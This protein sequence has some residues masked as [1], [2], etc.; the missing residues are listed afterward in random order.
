[1]GVDIIFVFKMSWK[2]NTN[3]L[4]GVSIK[5]SDMNYDTK[6]AITKELAEICGESDLKPIIISK[7][8]TERLNAKLSEGWVC[9]IGKEFMACI[10][11]EPRNF[12][13]MCFLGYNFI[14]YKAIS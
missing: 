8:L 6:F 10:S 1:M 9:I 5:H 2:A 12:M 7:L 4:N 11:H 14:V 3:K 13:R